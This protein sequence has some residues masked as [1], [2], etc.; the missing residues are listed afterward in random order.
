MHQ[1]APDDFYQLFTYRIYGMRL[2]GKVSMCLEFWQRRRSRGENWSDFGWALKLRVAFCKVNLILFSLR[3]SIGGAD[4][5]IDDQTPLS[6]LSKHPPSP[7]NP[8]SGQSC[9][10]VSIDAKSCT[11]SRCYFGLLCAVRTSLGKDTSGWTTELWPADSTTI[12]TPGKAPF[13]LLEIIF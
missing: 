13:T 2:K 6:C 10:E 3:L 1:L 9:G 5:L 12:F 4:P 8:H 7:P 11:C